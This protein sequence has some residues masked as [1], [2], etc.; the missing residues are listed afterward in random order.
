MDDL[1]P[2][3]YLLFG[4]IGYGFVWGR[5][6]RQERQLQKAARLLGLQTKI[7]GTH[8]GMV[9]ASLV[10]LSRKEEGVLLVEVESRGAIP[11]GFACYSIGHTNP[12]P[13]GARWLSGDK[14]FDKEIVLGGRK[15]PTI[16]VLTK[17]ARRNLSLLRGRLN[18]AY[19]SVCDGRMTARIT[20]PA[21]G[22]WVASEMVQYMVEAVE[23]LTL[24]ENA[25]PAAILAR[26]A[27]FSSRVFRKIS[28]EALFQDFPNHEASSLAQ[29]QAL[30][31]PSPEIK[32]LAASRL[33]HENIALLSNLARTSTVAEEDRIRALETLESVADAGRRRAVLLDI[34]KT[35]TKPILFSLAARTAANDHIEDAIPFLVRALEFEAPQSVSAAAYALGEL[36]EIGDNATEKALIKALSHEEGSVRHSVVESLG[37]IGSRLSIVPLI[38]LTK[39]ILRNKDLG[40][41]AED[42]LRRIRTRIGPAEG[43]R[44]SV[45]DSSTAGELSLNT[46]EGDLSFPDK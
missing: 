22:E 9:G 27:E 28:I 30:V 46:Q 21:H 42:A 3:V 11:P 23:A 40:L 17:D 34:L 29:Q 26:T 2:L 36:A 16:A 5:W 6:G 13:H 8:A 20:A 4:A 15:A 37:L 41:A 31:D 10:T 38:E 39:G 32:L 33:G 1:L 43:G 12:P 25:I 7:G 18:G 19:F 14:A 45:V 24:E 44:L 35:T